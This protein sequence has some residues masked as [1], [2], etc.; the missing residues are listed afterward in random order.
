MPTDPGV[1]NP[2]R[3]AAERSGTVRG[4]VAANVAVLRQGRDVV[5]RVPDR[6]WAQETPL[7]PGGTPGRHVRHCIDFYAGLL[8][9][10]ELGR[11]DYVSR[12]RDPRTEADRAYALERLEDAARSLERRVAEESDLDLLVRGE[13]IGDPT[14]GAW[15]RSTLRREL[16]FLLSHTV[17]HFAL[18]ALLLR[19]S[20][21]EPPAEFGVAASTLRFRAGPPR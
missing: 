19:V 14:A 1:A 15:T 17:H 10:L 3:C 8:R 21:L 20:G 6:L 2:D 9:G 18:L 13:E 12:A 11:I 5:D 4:L 7:T 16:Q